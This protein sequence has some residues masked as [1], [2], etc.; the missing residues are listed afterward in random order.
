M[1]MELYC[2][3]GNP[4]K[5]REFQEAA[6]AGVVIRPCG[7]LPCP[8]TGD[9]FE[10]NAVEKALCYGKS[11]PAEALLFV[12]DSGIE[13]DALNGAPG[14]YSARF[15]GEGATDA[16][17]NRLLLEKLQGV[18]DRAAR[19][20]C[21]I[22]LVQGGEVLAAFRA[23]AEG[24]IQ[25]QP[26]GANGF[27]Y[28]PYFYFPPAKRTFGQLTPAEKWPHSHRGKAF[29]KLLDWLARRSRR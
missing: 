16:D 23:E 12:D 8:E 20:V 18:A 17:N 22:A 6:G 10:A 28:D 5:L 26:Q 11:L 19:Y 15:A 1:P 4:G 3:T 29:R 21:V 27:G 14:V 9:T 25:D 7:P 24:R 13:V 2:G